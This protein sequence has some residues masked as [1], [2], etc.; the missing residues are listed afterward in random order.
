MPYDPYRDNPWRQPDPGGSFQV[1]PDD[2]SRSMQNYSQNYMADWTDH[3]NPLLQQAQQG[4]QQ[5]QGTAQDYLKQVLGGRSAGEAQMRAGLGQGMRQMSAQ[6]LSRGANPSGERAAIYAGANLQAD[7]IGKAAQLRAQ[8]EEQARQALIGAQQ[9]GAS[10]AMNQAQFIQQQQQ[11]AMDAARQAEAMKE[12][13]KEADSADAG[14]IMGSAMGALGGA[15][16]MFSDA[17]LKRD[18]QDAGL[19]VDAIASAAARKRATYRVDFK[20]GPS[21]EARFQLA[22]RPGRERFMSLRPNVLEPNTRYGQSGAPG[23]LIRPQRAPD[24]SYSWDTGMIESSDPETGEV[25]STRRATDAEELAYMRRDRGARFQADPQQ[26]PEPPVDP[27]RYAVSDERSKRI[28]SSQREQIDAMAQQMTEAMRPYMRRDG[29]GRPPSASGTA[30]AAGLPSATPMDEDPARYAVSD[31]HSKRIISRQREQIDDLLHGA[32][33]NARGNALYGRMDAMD[34][35]RTSG[36]RDF[37]D[38][39][40]QG[41]EDTGDFWDQ[42]R[43][44]EQRGEQIGSDIDERRARDFS[45]SLYQGVEDVG[46]YQDARRAQG[47]ARVEQLRAELGDAG[48]TAPW[49]QEE[50]PWDSMV[51]RRRRGPLSSPASAMAAMRSRRSG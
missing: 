42:Y 35:A 7:T 43:A 39:L 18:I 51:G 9:F 6:A 30:R 17:A 11:A 38:S 13:Q 27:T 20:T 12:G 21:G 45:D 41:A 1:D 44:G 48:E 4:M 5:Q 14:N 15:A 29:G 19:D 31:E 34:E 37:S 10:G 2:P 32:N 49:R 8:E 33:P 46:A 24:E 16:M 50:S 3:T 23:D 28:I 22:P 40:Y 47:D 36:E 25:I 26:A